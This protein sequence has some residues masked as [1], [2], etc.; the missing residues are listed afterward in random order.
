VM[1]GRTNANPDDTVYLAIDPVKA[2]LFDA[3]SGARLG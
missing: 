3:A 1:H 2:H